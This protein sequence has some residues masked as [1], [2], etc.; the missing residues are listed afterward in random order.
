MAKVTYVNPQGV[1]ANKIKVGDDVIS[2]NGRKFAD[3]LDYIYADAATECTLEVAGK[4]GIRK[5]SCK[6]NYDGDTLGLEFDE[7]V[8]I[9][10]P[11]ECKNNCIFCF[12][13]QLPKGMRDTLYVKDDDYRLSFISGC[14][15]TCTNLSEADIERIIEYKL[16]PLYIS[17]HSTEHE[18]RNM[19]LG[20]KKSIDQMALIKRFVAAGIVLNTQIVLCGG[21]ND[22]EHLQRSLN[23]LYDAG[24]HSVAVVPVGLTGHRT[25]LYDLQPLTR[26]QAASAIELVEDFYDKHEGFCYCSDE[27]YERAEL[28][29]K[30]YEYYGDFDQIDNG[31]GIVSQFYKEVKD[32]LEFAPKKLKKTVGIITGVSAESSM[33]RIKKLLESKWSGFKMNIYVVKNHFFGESV[34]V[35][36]LVTAT[37]IIEQYRGYKFTEDILLIPSVMM[38]QFDDVFLDNV[39]L[40]ELQEKLGK[41]ITVSAVDGDCFV[42]CIVYGD[43]K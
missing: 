16:S 21:I 20:I 40:A 28:S 8:E 23:D 6:K 36:G 31:V 33:K 34:T 42:D 9:T 29:V 4:N 35:A 41:K 26:E 13:K 2:F 14:Y 7:S 22:G 10:N 12:V 18:L 19:M 32:A 5:V 43:N 17:V 15:I 1:L 24:V 30:D 25:G 27:M 3:I 38:K 39:S 11:I 37:D